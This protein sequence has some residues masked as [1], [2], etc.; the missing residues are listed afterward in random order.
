MKAAKFYGGTDIR[1]EDVPEPDV[2]PDEVLVKVTKAG[3]CGSDLH[4]YRNPDR[5]SDTG[6]MTGHE[7]AGEVAAI[8][9]NVDHVTV[10]QIVGVE[11]RHLVGCGKCRWCR[12]GNYQLCPDLGVVEGKR[13]G[14]TGFAEYSLESSD[15]IY[16]LPDDVDLEGAAILDVYAVS[17]HAVN[18]VPVE[19]HQVVA[20]L[21]TGPIG[22]SQVQIARA[23]GAG[24]IIAVG[25][26]KNSLDVALEI[27]A[28][29]AVNA[30]DDNV[31]EAV[32]EITN[33][34]GADVVYESVGGKSTAFNDAIDI[35]ARGG[36]ICIIGAFTEP[37]TLEPRVCMRKEANIMWS[38]S[39]GMWD[40]ISE[41][42]IALDMLVDGRI[43]ARKLITHHFPLT[44]IA[45]AFAAAHDKATSGAIKVLVEP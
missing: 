28:D 45:N 1:V 15:K 10:G 42:K 39:Y 20:V 33:G 25:R 19:P 26:R 8:G 2:G 34:E 23:S 40:G 24:T 17:V 32:N 16:P 22:L 11:P 14:S 38:W 12:T 4:G 37:Q 36:R 29:F 5:K 44:D 7:L 3:I 31:A 21:G 9:A 18:R 30:L 27:G 43:D 13:V 6:R 41:Y 35:L